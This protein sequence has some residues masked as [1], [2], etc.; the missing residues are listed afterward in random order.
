MNAW[1]DAFLAHKKVEHGASPHTLE[2]YGRDLA[3]FAAFCVSREVTQVERITQAEVLGF[4]VRRRT[5]DGVS[6][7]TAQRNLVAVRGF[8]KFLQSEGAIEKNP[9]ELV[10]LQ[11][12]KV[13]LPKT[14][15]E[16]EVESLL[17]APDTATHFGLRDRAM[18]EVLYASGLRVSEL[19]NLPLGA[20]RLDIGLLRVLGK[21]RKERLVP[22]GDEA[23]HWLLLYLD[24]ARPALLKQHD[25][26][27]VFIS[28]QFGPM[29]RQH[30]HLLVD[31]YGKKAGIKRKISP[32]VLRH[33]FA[34]HLLAHGADLRAVQEMLGHVDLSTTEIYTHV[35]RERLK[36]MHDRHHPRGGRN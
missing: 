6:A 12:T 1:I 16:S 4:V 15:S 19:V 17:A 35:S 13:R 7:A 24:R 21:R 8:L 34:T 22:L 28:K 33:S 9:A 23:I 29:T 10:D 20:L 14:L 26:D 31:R 11:K 25:S 36:Q 27:A 2:A 32:H 18:L 5:V 30:F 3:A